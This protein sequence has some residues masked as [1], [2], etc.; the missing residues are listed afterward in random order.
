MADAIVINKADGKNERPA[1]LAKTAF[2][3]A[4]HLYPPK[5]S[6]WT[7]KVTTCSA[8]ENKG[9][10]EIWEL[11]MTY[12]KHT[13]ENGYFI[14]KRHEQNTYAGKFP[15][16]CNKPA[17]E[18]TQSEHEIPFVIIV[19]HLGSRLSAWVGITQAQ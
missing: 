16:S 11:I 4:L 2:A 13:Q 7:P 18:R 12:K 6:Q 5:D 3:K 17:N 8:L 9:I 19:W 1:R 15:Q 10:S 14:T